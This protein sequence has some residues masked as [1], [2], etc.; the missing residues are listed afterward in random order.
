MAASKVVLKDDS[1][2]D[3]RAAAMA[4]LTVERKAG[5]MAEPTGAKKAEAR[6][7]S[8]DLMWAA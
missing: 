6:V 7:A 1:T 5:K 8:W 2:A 3:E 4:V